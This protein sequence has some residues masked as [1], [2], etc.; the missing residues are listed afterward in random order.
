LADPW[1]TDRISKLGGKD[2]AMEISG[3]WLVELAELDALFK[4]ALS[5]TKSFIIRRHDR[6][7]PP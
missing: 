4:A 5:A 1:F 7:R 6:F 3:I 2:A